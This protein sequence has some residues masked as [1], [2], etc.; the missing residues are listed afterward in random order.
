MT[1]RQKNVLC[2]SSGT[3][4]TKHFPFHGRHSLVHQNEYVAGRGLPGVHLSSS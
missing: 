4:D 2:R 3:K 1:C